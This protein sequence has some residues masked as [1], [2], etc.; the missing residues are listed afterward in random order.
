[1]QQ[2]TDACPSCRLYYLMTNEILCCYCRLSNGIIF[3][4]VPSDCSFSVHNL[5]S[6]PFRTIYA[7]CRFRLSVFLSYKLYMRV[8]GTQANHHILWSLLV[9]SHVHMIAVVNLL[10]YKNERTCQ[11]TCQFVCCTRF[12]LLN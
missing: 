12:Y 4:T 7:E 10:Y 1:M 3:C 2:W 9:S 5:S 6:F 11:T 8:Y